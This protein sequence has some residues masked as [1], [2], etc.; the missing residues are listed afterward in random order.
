VNGKWY[1]YDANL[2]KYLNSLGPKFDKLN[3]PGFEI[4]V[5]GGG[6]MPTPSRRPP[7]SRG[8]HHPGFL[9]FVTINGC[10]ASMIDKVFRARLEGAR[11]PDQRRRQRLR[12]RRRLLEPDPDRER[13]A[14]LRAAA[15][16]HAEITFPSQKVKVVPEE[17]PSR[18]QLQG[19][20]HTVERVDDTLSATT[21][22]VSLV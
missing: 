4:V 19:I 15:P 10:A 1:P 17:G 22:Q 6:G 14:Q 12:D 21:S 20:L 16:D 11:V 2:E 13:A 8:D 5:Q 7:P 9:G 18:N 3:I